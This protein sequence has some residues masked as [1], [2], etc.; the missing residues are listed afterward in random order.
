MNA[1]QM[2]EKI[3]LM[4]GCIVSSADCSEIEIADARVRGDFYVDADG[5]G[6][7]RRLP[8]WLQLHSR[9]ARNRS[10]ACC[11]LVGR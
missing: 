9:D 11:E 2:L 6:F 5:F 10:E 4:G 1:E 7:V 8:E 3:G